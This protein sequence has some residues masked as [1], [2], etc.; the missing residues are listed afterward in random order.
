MSRKYKIL[1][2]THVYHV[3]FTV[4]H[5]LDIFIR[6]AYKD[7]FLDSIRYCQ[8]NKGLEVYAYCIMSSH[9]HMIIGRNGNIPIEGIIR[10]IKKYT[11]VKIIEAIAENPQESRKELLLWL[12]ERA[13]KKNS[14]NVRYQFWMQH[15]HPIALISPAM[16]SQ[17]LDYIHH[18]PVEAGIVLNPEEYLYSSA[19]NYAG[20]GDRV[21]EVILIE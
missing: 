3:T 13:G 19:R 4:I 18:N 12:F 16:I 6:R 9:I 11:S 8:Q 15:N 2:Q 7:L 5:W 17:R 20:L 14:N 1:D 21:L 10:D